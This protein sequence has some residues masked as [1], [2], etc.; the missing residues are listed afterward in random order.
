MAIYFLLGKLS[1]RGQEQIRQN[2]DHLIEAAEKMRDHKAQMLG[3]YAVLGHYD[4]IIMVQAEENQDVARLSAELGSEAGVHF[5][6][7]AGLSTK[8]MT[9]HIGDAERESAAAAEPRKSNATTL[10]G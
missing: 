1:D 4:L 2:P 3:Q 7:L 6:T 5:E 9:M 10:L 8:F